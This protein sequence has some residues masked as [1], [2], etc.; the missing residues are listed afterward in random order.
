M[1]I[2]VS[3]LLIKIN[4]I[5]LF[6]MHT[7]VNPSLHGLQLLNDL[8]SSPSL[9][10]R[11]DMPLSKNV[12]KKSSNKGKIDSEQIQERLMENGRKRAREES[13]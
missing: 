5:G 3:N 7:E 12:L 10:H 9:T 8:C 2:C 11:R 1:Q 4:Q 6:V 13:G